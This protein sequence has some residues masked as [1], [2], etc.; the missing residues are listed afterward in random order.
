MYRIDA[1]TLGELDALRT[2]GGEYKRQLVSTP[3]GS[4]WMVYFISVLWQAARKY[5]VVIGSKGVKTLNRKSHLESSTV[6]VT[7]LYCVHPQRPRID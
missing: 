3:Y 1:T 5:R 4:A 7:M 2:K 6:G